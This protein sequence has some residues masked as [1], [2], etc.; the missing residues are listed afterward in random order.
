MP[1]LKKWNIVVI[2]AIFAVF[3]FGSRIVQL[4]T[5]YYW[6][7][8]IGFN[9][10]FQKS[11]L[12]QIALFL[13]VTSLSWALLALNLRFAKK[14]SRK[15]FVIIGPDASITAPFPTP[16]LADLR[17]LLQPILFAGTFVAAFLLGSWAW[18][19][20]DIVLKFLNGVSFQLQDPLFSRDISFYV[21]KVPFYKF[22]YH[23]LLAATLL[24]LA[25]SVVTYL[26]NNRVYLS[27]RGIQMAEDSKNHIV[28]LL[29]FLFLLI[30]AHFQINI[31]DLLSSQR[32]LAPG[33]GF[34]NVHATLPILKILRIA[35][36]LGAIA[37]WV[38]PYFPNRKIIL[39]TT[40]S[41]AG[42]ALLGR[43]YGDAIQ[44]FE[45]GPNE[46]SK[47]TPYLQLAI[48]YTRQAYGLTDI[49][50]LEFDPQE[51]LTPSLLKKNELT[52][53]NIRLWEHK[54]LLTS[55]GQ[56]QEI[57]TYYD[58]LDADNDRYRID[59]QYRQ[60]MLSVRELL[61]E[62]LP[63]RIWI[64][65]HLTYTHGYGICMG[66]VNRISPEGLPEFFIKDIPPSSSIPLKVTQPEIYFGEARSGYS[67]VKTKSKE[68]DYPA[69]DQNVY[70]EYKGS[71]GV[72]IKNFLRKILFALRF[73]EI[74][75]LF[76]GNITSD[77]RILYHRSIKERLSKAAP[78]LHFDNDP[79]I[80]VA[81][82]GKL[83]WIVDGYTTTDR[84]P[85]SEKIGNMNYIKNSVKATVD[86]Y[87][88]SIRLYISDPADP[89]VQTYARIF[90]QILHSMEEM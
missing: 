1:E 90:P 23:F 59:G 7:N 39:I 52:L 67:I 74:K 14:I 50:E 79:Y 81:D 13:V 69:G 5:D 11:F 63:S 56:L 55:Y 10:L 60:V 9:V 72:P 21:F 44:K 73:R 22:L 31:W 48:Q 65:E 77:S 49:Q 12:T 42:G 38:S 15:P 64:N 2:A 70:T 82:D 32:N 68:F 85:Y 26:L 75:I 19:Q 47:E 4:I 45:V 36:V 88:G 3:S 54:P 41:L 24:S 51:N 6:F 8:E 18:N 16:Q 40:L 28:L 33:A 20:W 27:N 53:N 80:V 66:P 35:A 87:E 57:R 34:T 83:F 61:A 62:S 29:G 84:Y 71:G 58:F 46:I 25:M 30:G 17:N 37:A 76:T 43:L 86:A 78:F 89:I